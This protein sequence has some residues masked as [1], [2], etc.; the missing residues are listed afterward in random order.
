MAHLPGLWEAQVKVQPS[1]WD[2]HDGTRKKP[3]KVTGNLQVTKRKMQ[4]CYICGEDHD[5]HKP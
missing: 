4:W 1:K 2:K 3:P 5:Y